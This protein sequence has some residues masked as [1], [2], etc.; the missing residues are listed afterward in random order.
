MIP[1]TGSSGPAGAFRLIA[2][3]RGGSGRAVR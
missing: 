2:G 1:G 3:R